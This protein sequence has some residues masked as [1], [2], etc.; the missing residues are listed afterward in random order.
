M[1]VFFFSSFFFFKLK[2]TLIRYLNDTE[3]VEVTKVFV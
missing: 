1:E 2:G 3:T